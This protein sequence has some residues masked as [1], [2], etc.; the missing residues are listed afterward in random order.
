MRFATPQGFNQGVDFETYVKDAFDVLYREGET[1]PK[2]LSIGLHCRLIGRPARFAALERL[3][4]YILSHD[5][6]WVCR[7]VD[8]ARHWRAQFPR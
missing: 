7:R 4:D 2:M 8:I 6:V 5:D 3:V 1:A